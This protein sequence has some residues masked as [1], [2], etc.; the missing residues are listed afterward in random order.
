MP[1]LPAVKIERCSCFY[2]HAQ[3]FCSHCIS[4]E[5]SHLTI[6]KDKPNGITGTF[7]K[8]NRPFLENRWFTTVMCTLAASVDWLRWIGRTEELVRMWQTHYQCF[9]K[10]RVLLWTSSGEV[11]RADWLSALGH[12]KC[13]P[14]LHFPVQVHPKGIQL[15]N[16]EIL[17]WIRHYCFCANQQCISEANQLNYPHFLSF[18]L[19]HRKS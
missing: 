16:P 11:Q 6:W 1:M 4:I 13:P 8:K 12:N 15:V 18:G 2:R 14:S 9:R 10:W 17:Q 5:F 3:V 19:H 7:H